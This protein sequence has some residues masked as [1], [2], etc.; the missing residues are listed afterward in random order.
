MTEPWR[1]T[2]VL[3]LLLDST[4]E[5]IYGI[6]GSGNCTFCNSACLRM[7]GYQDENQLV[8]RKIHPLMHHTR[9]DGLLYPA[10]ECPVYQ[11]LRH[12]HGAHEDKEVF[13]R[14]DG[15][16]FPVEY[17]SHPMV[18]GSRI[19]GVVVTFVD[20]TERRKKEQWT[21]LLGRAIEGASELIGIAD[22]AGRI[23]YANPALLT[24]LGFRLE[25]LYG[26]SF[27][28]ILSPNNPSSLCETIARESF[29]PNGWKGE[30]LAPRRN[31]ADLPISLSSSQIRDESGRSLG[32]IGIAEDITTRKRA[33]EAIERARLAAEASNRAKSEFLANMSHEIR[34]P[35][36]GIMGM[37][38]L[39]LE[40]ELTA[41]QSEYLAM[42]KSSAESL[43]TIIGDILDFSKI[44]AG[45]LEVEQISF[46]LRKSL[47]DT[48]RTLALKAEQKGLEFIFDVYPEVPR[49]VMGDPTRLRQV[50]VNLAGNAVKFTEK[51]EI[52]IQA[53]VEGGES[54]GAMLHFW[55]RDTGIGIPEEK[56]KMIFE[57]FSQV[58][59]STTRQ[60]GGTGLGLSISNR[61]VELMKGRMWLESRSGAGSTFHFVIPLEAPAQAAISGK[62]ERD[63]LAGIPI[64]IVD[65]NETNRRM[66]ENCVTS[67]GMSCKSTPD[68]SSCLELLQRAQSSGEPLPILLT[69][70]HMP[71]TDGFGLIE[72]IRQ[73][74]SFQPMK[75]VVLTS[76]GRRGDGA[77]CRELG[78]S[79][80]LTK[81]IDR[82]ELREA[83]L[84]VHAGTQAETSAPALL[85]RH[86][87]REE[88]QPLSF[89]LA[90]DNVVNQR[91]MVRLLEKRGHRVAVAANGRDAL[92]AM[93][94]ENF[95]VVL[96]DVQMPVMDGFET[97]RRIREIEKAQGSHTVIIAMTANA[98]KG[99]REKCLAA[100][101]DGY[102]S[103]P[104]K[105]DELFRVVAGLTAEG[106]VPAPRLDV[107]QSQRK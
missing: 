91:L 44:E 22:T 58:D 55:V 81:P 71:G 1:N 7:L 77:R 65:D 94:K 74:T 101:M 26:E 59:A 57:A 72:A 84:R 27:A 67:W 66:L 104:L 100:G 102:V 90:E 32:I 33:V 46:D 10:A 97:T 76:G 98:L 80:Y 52:A 28:R 20:V 88:S 40:T 19:I 18:Q 69:D 48:M 82:L 89:L 53:R 36:N 29:S 87:I 103:K 21:Y 105:V 83:L 31:G 3:R 39:L 93:G 78:V 37:T 61:L 64:L 13:W 63:G 14:S 17:W 49:L 35:M 12:G 45:K 73:K 85:T 106:A 68:A 15:S 62:P 42:V 4:A 30:C 50:L 38:D 25:E 75:I 96:M 43:L 95:D 23:T 41:E 56:Q 2:E 8:G 11:S 51:G 6:N 99:D 16:S 60:Y 47:S 92:A 34:T 86:V 5:G 79:A 70:G 54:G 24:T 107:E 9:P